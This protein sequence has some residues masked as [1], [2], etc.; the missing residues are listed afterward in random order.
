VCGGSF[1]V[2]DRTLETLLPSRKGGG[3]DPIASTPWQACGAANGII[4]GIAFNDAPQ[5]GGCGAESACPQQ[6]K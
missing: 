2:H 1:C 6:L 4:L 3:L 5:D